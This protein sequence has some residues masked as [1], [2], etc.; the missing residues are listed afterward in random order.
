M[1]PSRG[2]FDPDLLRRMPRG[3]RPLTWIVLLIVAA[4]TTYLG[5]KQH[6]RGD[7]PWR[8]LSQSGPVVVAPTA[9]TR[10]GDASPEVG[11][12]DF[13]QLAR[14]R[15]SRINVESSGVAV[16]ILPDDT[17]GDQHQRFLV[18]VGGAKGS[19][20]SST[21]LIAHNID[22]AE[23]VP[24]REGDAVRFRGEFEWNDRGGVVHWTHRDPAH[25]HADGWIE[26]GGKRYQ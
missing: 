7:A 5:T 19:D 25:R 17:E 21:I 3:R 15:R 24:V 8:P 18:R 2:P 23:R 11:D 6:E 10:S 4:V 13:A 22:L 26:V 14:D 9:P 16:K 20:S 1:N 12:A